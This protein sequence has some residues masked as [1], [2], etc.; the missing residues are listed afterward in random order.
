MEQ[1]LE[2]IEKIFR[3]SLNYT[4][5]YIKILINLIKSKLDESG[6]TNITPHFLYATLAFEIGRKTAK[7][8]SED[9]DDYKKTG[10][11]KSKLQRHLD[12]S[13]WM[14]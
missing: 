3:G 10:E 9:F 14:K 5:D 1:D 7:D 4:N 11:Y 8:V 13:P 6:K 2:T 12:R